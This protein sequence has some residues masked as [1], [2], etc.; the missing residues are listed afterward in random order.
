MRIVGFD[1]PLLEA[2]HTRVLDVDGVEP[3]VDNKWQSFDYYYKR[4]WAR[5]VD[6]KIGVPVL[7]LGNRIFRKSYVLICEKS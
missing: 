6:W 4:V 7:W 1:L 2:A 3:A 5:T